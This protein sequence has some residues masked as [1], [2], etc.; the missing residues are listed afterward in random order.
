MRSRIA[1]IGGVVLLSAGVAALAAGQER[2]PPPPPPPP[3]EGAPSTPALQRLLGGKGQV[4]R[5]DTGYQAT[6]GIVWAPNNVLIF[7]DPPRN[8]VLQWSDSG[9]PAI[10]RRDSGGASGL[11]L[12]PQG[13]VLEADRAARR[14]IRI[15]GAQVVTVLD[16]VGGAPLG[17][18]SDVA[19]APDGALYVA[20]VTSS[21]GRVILVPTS[22]DPGVVATDLT[23]PAGLAV[24]T[25]GKVLYVTDSVKAELRAYPIESDGRLGAGRRLVAVVPWKRGVFGRPAGLALDREGRIYMAGPGGIWVLD[26]NGGRLGV[27]ATPETPSACTFGDPDHKTL[28]LTAE[29]SV[30]KVRLTVAG[31]R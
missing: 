24:S 29:T 13:R 23:R 20:D 7:T 10:E 4:Q 1:R 11:A 8:H 26:A 30:Y 25:D 21:G 19:V 16:R 12:D 18:P 27:I 31:A 6:D 15:E 17:G 5:V 14:V 9:Q 3:P 22:G 28:Y 2:L